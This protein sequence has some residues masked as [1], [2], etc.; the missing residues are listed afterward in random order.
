[1]WWIVWLVICVGCVIVEAASPQL[2]S[3]WFALGALFALITSLIK[4]DW[5]W[6]QLIVFVVVS[7]VSLALT[8]PLAKKL[9][10][11]NKTRINADRFIDEEGVVVQRINNVLGEG[12]VKSKGTV[13]SARSEDDGV[14]IEEG[15]HV[16]IK[17]IEGVKVIVTEIRKEE[18]S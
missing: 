12:Q 1:M 11:K 10:S 3:V 15:A 16:K 6:L 17:R 7:A 14:M 18:E 4:P 13:W 9:L 2:T 5:W 8:R